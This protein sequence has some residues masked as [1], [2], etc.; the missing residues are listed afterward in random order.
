[1]ESGWRKSVT[2][3]VLLTDIT[4]WHVLPLLFSLLLYTITFHSILFAMM[5]SLSALKQTILETRAPSDHSLTLLR[6][7][8]QIDLSS[9]KIHFQ[10][11][12]SATKPVWHRAPATKL[13]THNH[14][15]RL[16]TRKIKLK[17]PELFSFTFEVLNSV[18]W[19]IKYAWGF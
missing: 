18:Y 8:V 7:W 9:H 13:W 16:G 4:D 15:S 12:F 6:P 2:G 5:L 14:F 10:G 19:K 1:M 17:F 3:A 11:F